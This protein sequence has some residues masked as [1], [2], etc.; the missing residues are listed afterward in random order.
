MPAISS[1]MPMPRPATGLQLLERAMACVE[2]PVR[3]PWESAMHASLAVQSDTYEL[4]FR[5]LFHEGRGLAFP[6]DAAGRVDI[7][8]LGE[9]AR[10]NYLAARTLIGRDF[11]APA[12][13][14]AFLH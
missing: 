11:A 7:D 9:R 3:R 13:T 5:S 10:L 8:A 6:C 12:V 2:P 14:P 4:R 1:V